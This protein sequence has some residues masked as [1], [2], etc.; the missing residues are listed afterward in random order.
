MMS[1][2]VLEHPLASHLLACLRDKVTAPEEF[3]RATRALSMLLALEATRGLAVTSRSVRTPVAETTVEE[4]EDSLAVVPI[5]R[6]GLGMLDP[7]LELFPK[8][9]V[10]YIGLE[11]H[12]D[13]AI[14]HSYYC[15]LPELSGKVAICLDPMLATGGSA[16]QAVALI[17]TQA[18]KRVFMVSIVAAPEGVQRMTEDHPEVPIITAALDQGLNDR[19]YIVPGVGDYGDRLFGT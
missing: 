18:P 3:R 6:A 5:L 1:L 8:V 19:R 4:I 12:E 10:G 14:A 7:I 17:K 13:T 16:S 15:K 9:D 2:H 11:R